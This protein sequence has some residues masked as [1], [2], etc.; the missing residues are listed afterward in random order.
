MEDEDDD[1]IA[2]AGR[3]QVETEP[4]ELIGGVGYG[5]ILFFAITKD[6]CWFIFEHICQ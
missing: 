3:L 2:E 6:N 1:I 5:L 4:P